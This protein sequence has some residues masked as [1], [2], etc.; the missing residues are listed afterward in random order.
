RIRAVFDA[1]LVDEFQDTDPQQWEIVR[2][3]FHGHRTLVLVGDPKQSIYG[4]RGAE[5]L[6]YLQAV[7]SAGALRALDV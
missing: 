3:C 7:R 6:S 2:R 5:I 4:F 1:V